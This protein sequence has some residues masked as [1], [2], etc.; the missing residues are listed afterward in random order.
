MYL[1]F[2]KLKLKSPNRKQLLSW[3]IHQNQLL[4]LTCSVC[5][6]SHNNTYYLL[7]NHLLRLLLIIFQKC[8]FPKPPYRHICKKI[9]WSAKISISNRKP[10]QIDPLQVTRA[11]NSPT[12]QRPNFP[13]LSLPRIHKFTKSHFPFISIRFFTIQV[14]SNCSQQQCRLLTRSVCP[15]DNSL[16]GRK[17]NM[18]SISSRS[19][20]RF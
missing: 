5:I 19:T 11:G 1:P 18:Y 2:T 15:S 13:Q 4:Q 12:I 7:P 10:K 8:S 6:L 9:L 14:C 3:R 16:S 20:E 17:E